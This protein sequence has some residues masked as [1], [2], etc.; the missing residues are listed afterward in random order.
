MNEIKRLIYFKICRIYMP[1]I[2]IQIHILQLKKY[3][4]LDWILSF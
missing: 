3:K 1:W 4:Y 2:M